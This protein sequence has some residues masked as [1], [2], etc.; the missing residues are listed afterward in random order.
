MSKFH[1]SYRIRT[2]VGSDTQ[3]HVKLDNDYD[4]LEIMSLKIDQENAYK[5]HT[6][7]YG[8][9]AGRVLANE[10]FG[11]PN[12]K[13]SVFINIDNEDINDVVKSVLYPYNT[14]SSKNKDGVRYN[15]LTEE[16]I[17]DCHTVIGTFPEKQYMLNNDNILEVFEKYYKF[18]T[19]TNK[20]GDYMIFGVPTGSQTIHVDIDLSDIGILSQRPRDMVYKGYNIEQFENPNKFKY[21]T[22]LDSLTHVISQDTITDVIPFWGDDSNTSIGITRCDINIQYKFEPTCVFMGSVVSDNS[23]NGISKK[24]VPMPGMGVMEDMT[25]GSGTIEMI[26]KTPS[27][28]VEEFQIKGTQLING[29]GVWCYQI[30][31]NLDYVKT[32]EY[33]NTVPTDDP[34]KGIPTRT[35]VRFRISLQDFD[36]NNAN[37]FRCKMLVPH[38]P[39]VYSD[40]C[41]DE[42]DYQF[43]TKTSENSY[44]DLFWNGV[45]SVKSYIPRIQKGANWKNEKFTGFKRVNYHGSNNP[46]PYNNIR[47][48]IPLMYTIMCVIFKMMITLIGFLNRLFKLIG[49]SFVSQEDE[50]GNTTSGSYLTLSGEMCDES[51]ESLFLEIATNE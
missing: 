16:Q 33:G 4:T 27:G 37:I 44:R 11:I 41:S 22:N 42:L 30:P 51:L 47:I 15:L 21:D 6:S 49:K 5:L 46:L 8:V 26:R 45:Y 12:A 24:C 13:V 7:N 18:T 17:S 9:I 39:N 2:N 38:N 28:D 48:K 10:S 50:D 34:N 40:T 29:D 32:D 43:G 31:M 36:N 14:T 20:S 23:S 25:T 35:R 1:K 3:L 19:R